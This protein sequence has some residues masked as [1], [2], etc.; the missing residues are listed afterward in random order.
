MNLVDYEDL[1]AVACRRDVYV[2]END[3]ADLIDLRI[4]SGVEF[5]HVYR[6]AFGDFSARR[7]RLGIVDPAGA[8]GRF[9]G[10]M[11]VERLCQQTSGRRLSDTSR[12]RKQ[13]SMMQ[14][15]VLDRITKRLRNMLLAGDLV[16]SLRPPFS[17]NNL[18]GHSLHR[19][20]DIRETIKLG[21]SFD[22]K[23]GPRRGDGAVSASV[24]RCYT[25]K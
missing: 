3:V 14:P 15:P 8:Y 25:N 18:V 24:Y 5:E 12:P 1:A 16:K 17:G 6:T 13:V 22:R 21:A 2:L 20:M 7:T 11:A 23:T 9:L 10:L 19:I 4:R